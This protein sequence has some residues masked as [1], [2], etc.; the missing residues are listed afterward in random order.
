MAQRFVAGLASLAGEFRF[1]SSMRRL[2]PTPDWRDMM[3]PSA[4][5]IAMLALAGFAG[6]AAAQKGP[7]WGSGKTVAI[8]VTNDGFAP[9][10]IVLKSGRHYTLRFHNASNRGHNFSAQKFFDIAR[11]APRDARLVHD[12]EVNLDAGQVATVRIIAP[13][14]PGA[15]FTY[16]STVLADAG[17]KMKGDIYIVR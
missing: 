5:F 11:V 12:D 14:T 3:K 8:T 10:R 16:R 9:A 2:S 1:G 6:G 7:A 13:D 15:A 17:R 4:P